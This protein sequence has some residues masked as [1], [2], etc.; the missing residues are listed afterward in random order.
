MQNIEF[1]DFYK[2]PN[3]K[4]DITKLRT[5]LEKVL[6]KKKF[7]NLNLKSFGAIPILSLIHITEPTRPY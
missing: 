7:D 2:V 4:F 5:A 3:V 1:N 6:K